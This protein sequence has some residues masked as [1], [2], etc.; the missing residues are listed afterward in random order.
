MTFPVLPLRGGAFHRVLYGVREGLRRLISRIFDPLVRHDIFG[1]TIRL[2]W[3]HN[4]PNFRRQYPQYS[5]NVAR[6]AKAIAQKYPDL[7][8]IDIG[9]NVGD[10]VAFIR[11][12]TM[13]PILCIEADPR[14]FELL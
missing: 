13:A 7:T 11:S 14:F 9:S 6:I 8:I 5:S 4:L 12:A 10:T 3:S 2:P 1:Q